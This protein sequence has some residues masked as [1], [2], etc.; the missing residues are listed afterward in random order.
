MRTVHLLRKYN[1]DEWG[2][3]E[4]A[5]QR[6]FEGLR[7]HDVENVVYCPQLDSEP[8]S[9]PLESAGHKVK[10]FHAFVPIAGI[11]SAQK[12]QMISLGGNLMSFDLIGSLWR[13]ENVSVIHTHTLGRIG[14][15]A[16]TMARQRRVPF[17]VTI[18]GGVL[19]LPANLKNSFN[20]PV[21]G[22][23]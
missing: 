4:T 1:P 19:D 9:D 14:G 23:W 17:V 6:L 2:G 10:R 8:K 13:E 22:G 11:S 21:A 12:Q 18:H 16:L 15:I 7:E 5:I 20:A 3:T